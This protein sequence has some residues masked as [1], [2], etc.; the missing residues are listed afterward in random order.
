MLSSSVCSQ[1]NHYNTRYMYYVEGSYC[2]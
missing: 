2:F 1:V